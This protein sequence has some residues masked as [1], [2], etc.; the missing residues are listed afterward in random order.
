ML[1]YVGLGLLHTKKKYLF[2][3]FKEYTKEFTRLPTKIGDTQIVQDFDDLEDFVEELFPN[4]GKSSK[5]PESV[6]L[7]PK[8]KNMNKINEMCLDSYKPDTEVISLKST[9]KPYIPEQEGFIPE[10]LL[11]KYNPGGLPPHNLCLKPGCYLMLL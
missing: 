9:D 11:N 10:D 6:I 1:R 2:K 5:I 3:I 4:I 8:N 7:T